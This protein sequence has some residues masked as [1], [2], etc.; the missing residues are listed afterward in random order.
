MAVAAPALDQVDAEF[1]RYLVAQCG[2][3]DPKPL[4][5]GMY[6]AIFP[7]MFTHAI[8][9]GLIGDYDGYEGRWCFHNYAAAK[10]ALDAWNGDGEPSEWH[11]HPATGR[12]RPD[13]DAAREYVAR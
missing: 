11:R 5:E 9:T 2:Y 6:A 13:G 8:I 10:T 4:P 1:F 12:R 7:L 3:S